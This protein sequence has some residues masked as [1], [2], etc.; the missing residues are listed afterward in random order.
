MALTLFRYFLATFL[1]RTALALAG[2]ALPL[3]VFD[4]LAHLNGLLDGGAPVALALSAYAGLRLPTLV[5]LLVPLAV[6]IGGLLTLIALV[7]DQEIVVAR[8]AGVS[9]LQIAASLLVGAGLIA[10]AHFLFA[11]HVATET[12]ERLAG[13]QARNFAGLPTSGGQDRDGLWLAADRTILWIGHV[14][15][16]GLVLRDLRVIERNPAGGF[17]GYL[18]AETARFVDGRWVLQ[19]ISSPLAAA[20]VAGAPSDLGHRFRLDPGRLRN[21]DATP[22][23]LSFGA[24]W[25]MQGREGFAGRAP[26]YY[27]FWAHR[28]LAQ[29]ASSLVMALLAAPLA[30]QLGRRRRLVLIAL[31]TL[32]AG[33]V[34]FGLERLLVPLGETAVLPPPLAAWAPFI[35]FGALAVWQL[36]I[37][38]A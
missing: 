18:E 19:D 25:A 17:A 35:V 2:L 22:A 1:G 7:S 27:R 24:A 14:S 21:L 15:E 34:Y 26:R 8:A 33:A 23:A 31:A 9:T 29:P 12:A 4:T 5:V 37:T 38:E 36:I 3:S 6:L 13:W 28:K 10:T 32:A 11:N 30:C 20:D 16:N